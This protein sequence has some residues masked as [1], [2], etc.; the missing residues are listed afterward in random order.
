M[1]RYLPCFV[2]MLLLTGCA[3][4]ATSPTSRYPPAPTP[5]LGP[6]LRCPYDVSS[7]LVQSPALLDDARA[8][9]DVE[10][11]AATV[12]ARAKE[13]GGGSEQAH[14]FWSGARYALTVQLA[15]ST[16]SL[17]TTD[18][19]DMASTAPLFSPGVSP[20]QT[21]LVS[22]S[23]EWLDAATGDQVHRG[24]L[25]ECVH[26]GQHLL[27]L[28]YLA[29][30]ARVPDECLADA[31]QQAAVYARQ[32][33]YQPEPL[34]YA[35]VMLDARQTGEPAGPLLD[36]FRGLFPAERHLEDVVRSP[37]YDRWRERVAELLGST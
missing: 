5:A 36:T 23:P 28:G 37:A 27:R 6:T 14:P 15:S 35:V 19:T 11:C 20:T 31:N 1:R 24:A 32:A 7:A 25:R 26:V 2:C 13:G 22:V 33:G 18:I 9:A 12:V 8:A 29:T 17:A 3:V 4:P 16:G 10:A 30:E 34:A 21:I